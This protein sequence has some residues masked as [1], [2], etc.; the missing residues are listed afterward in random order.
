MSQNIIEVS[1]DFW[2]IRGSY[3]IAGLL[4]VG[5]QASLVR[6]GDGR[7]VLLDTCDFDAPTLAVIDEATNS[8]EN[9]AAVL[10]LH[11]FHTLHV[12]AFHNR[13]PTTALY[14]TARHRERLS[15]LPWEEEETS[16]EAL[17]QRFAD[18]FAFSVPRGVDL[19]SANENVHFSSV[20]AFHRSSKT[21]HSDDTF[22]YMGNSGMLRFT[23]LADTVSF[24]PTLSK[25]LEK[26]PGAARDFRD[27]ASMLIE[28]WRSAQNL[29]AA[30]T[31]ALI[32]RK[33]PDDPLRDRL[34]DAL[35]AVEQTLSKHEDEYG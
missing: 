9:L 30:H 5:T 28:H 14:G 26:R 11:P 31:A 16:S 21:I 4:N 34:V 33:N 12:K 17:H 18:D 7:W 22:N 15:D 1:R 10:N 23:P 6:L 13:Y 29:C 19:I 3:R 27:W 20:L 32:G 24:H 25:A 8:G 35:A 2:N